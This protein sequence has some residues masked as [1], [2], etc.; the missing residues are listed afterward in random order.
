M[1]D[2][3]LMSEVADGQTLIEKIR[4]DIKRDGQSMVPRKD[5]LAL[6][7]ND[8]SFLGVIAR[9]EN[10]N[11]ELVGDA[12]MR[13]TAAALRPSSVNFNGDGSIRT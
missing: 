7:S 11:Y 2:A 12:T 5:W 10:W 4:S 3:A 8:L 13:F 1:R 6:C 9:N